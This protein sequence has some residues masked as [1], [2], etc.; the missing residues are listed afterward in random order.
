MKTELLFILFLIFFLSFINFFLKKFNLSMDK[1]SNNE[2]HKT[3]LR[4]NN[5]TPLSG[6][7]YFLPIIFVL[8]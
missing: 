3:L 4:P 5:L 8:F 2:N 6:T 7:Y 1:V